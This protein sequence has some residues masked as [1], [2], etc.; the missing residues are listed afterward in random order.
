MIAAAGSREPQKDHQLHG[1]E[2]DELCETGK[3]TILDNIHASD[4][5]HFTQGIHPWHEVSGWITI[6]VP[7]GIQVKT[8]PRIIDFTPTL[9][10]KHAITL[11]EF[12][13]YENQF[14]WRQKMVNQTRSHDKV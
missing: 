10:H 8:C 7:F 13:A 12:L 6:P 14:K 3:V 2:R 9:N 1:H 11:Q 4:L 5:Q